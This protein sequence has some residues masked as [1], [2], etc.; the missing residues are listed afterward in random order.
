MVLV[1][2]SGGM[3]LT[4]G[5]VGARL[6]VQHGWGMARSLAIGAVL[7]PLT[8]AV[9]LCGLQKPAQRVAEAA[10]GILRLENLPLPLA[11]VHRDGR[12]I[13]ANR[14]LRQLLGYDL[15]ELVDRP[16]WELNAEP[17]VGKACFA[18]L[19]QVGVLPERELFYRRRDGRTVATTSTA[20]VTRG[21]PG[22]LITVSSRT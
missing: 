13:T 6:L 12:V 20:I 21:E 14:A 19:L 5:A 16:I 3:W 15:T 8:A 18:E 2:V 22:I 17:E 11:V 10:E 1:L 9:L 7:G 4:T